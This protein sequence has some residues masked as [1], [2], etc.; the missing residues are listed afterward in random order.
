MYVLS[1]AVT[2]EHFPPLLPN[3][4]MNVPW[5][6]SVVAGKEP[7]IASAQNPK[8]C[9]SVIDGRNVQDPKS[10]IAQRA[11]TTNIKQ[12]SSQRGTS[13]PKRTVVITALWIDTIRGTATFQFVTIFRAHIFAIAALVCTSVRAR[14]FIKDIK[15][16]L[17]QASS[18][19]SGCECDIVSSPTVELKDVSLFAGKRPPAC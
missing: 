16:L 7:V 11:G 19:G 15:R 4:M 1:C 2:L 8:S 3:N 12:I 5:N 9:Q 14:Q 13:L 18:V 6:V 10:L 17:I